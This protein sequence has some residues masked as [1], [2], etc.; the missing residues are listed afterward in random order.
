MAMFP[1]P[2]TLKLFACCFLISCL[3]VGGWVMAQEGPFVS[4]VEQLHEPLQADWITAPGISGNEA[5]LYYFRKSF[6]LEEAPESFP[7]H[8]SGDMRY[9]LLVNGKEVGWGPAVGDLNH[10]NYE[11]YDLAPWLRAGDNVLL[12]R[13]WNVGP[14]KGARQVSHQTGFI[15]QEEKGLG[16]GV[17]TDASWDVA[18]HEGWHP[19]PQSS[20]QAGGGYIA[21]ATDSLVMALDPLGPDLA[22]AGEEIW[23]PVR[24][25]GKGNHGGLN[26]WLG[27]PWLL[28]E[29][30][31][32]AMEQHYEATPAV[33]EVE[34][35]DLELSALKGN[36]RYGCP[37]NSKVRLLLDNRVLTMGFPELKVSGGSDAQVRIRYQEGLFDEYGRKGNRD[38]WQGKQMR[39][40]SDVFLPD[41]REGAVLR[42]LWIRVFR[43]V[44]IDIET[45]D[46][47]LQLEGF[48]NLFTAYPLEEKGSFTADSPGLEAIWEASWRTLRLCAL[49]TYMDCP[50]YE[51]LQYI[52]DTRIQALIS[53]LVA[54]DERL[55][56]QAMAQF[57]HSMQPMGLTKSSHPQSGIQIIPPFSLIYIGM[58]HD[59][60][61]M[62]KD[63]QHIA[64]YLPGVRF[65]LDWF[66]PRIGDDGMMGPL[67]Y[68]NHVD[69]G[70]R[71]FR[72]GSPPG[73]EEGG[74]AHMSILLAWAMQ[75]AADMF[76]YFGHDCDPEVYRERAAGLLE[77]TL[78]QCW[79][80]ER[81]LLA[82]TPEKELYT[83]HS[84][85]MAILAGAFEG[86][87]EGQ[88]ARRMLEDPELAQATLYFKFYL[89]QALKKA[90]LGG[91]ILGEM[92]AW[93]EFLD[94]GLST[95]PEHGAE[96]RS[97][98]HAWAAHPMYSFLN[99]SCGIASDAP[100]FK[101][102]RIAP[103]L[104][105]LGHA[106]GLACHPQGKIRVSFRREGDGM[107]ARIS[108]PEGLSGTL[109]WKGRE[110]P[111]RG[112]EQSFEL[113]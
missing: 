22:K 40:I 38:H 96:S 12:A 59:Y 62:G 85:A 111:L 99:V 39:G 98:C 49:E 71:E 47:A 80:D 89:F 95:F 94:L 86:G 70:T 113:K 37:P 92:E 109:V 69:G 58:I 42:P 57:Y 66:V 102:V 27:T 10:W 48:R 77:S 53:L 35:L 21:G 68:W 112:G 54:G 63:P 93:K 20:L 14:H 87:E 33:V 11:S 13:V 90:G 32:P 72:H 44:Q 6:Q 23:Q 64:S 29:R 15:L 60:F 104:G 5:G 45:G 9:Q 3:S 79:D 73:I 30:S 16:A 7:V 76:E 18:V 67:P 56:R 46:E 101:R 88:V 83:Q 25:L 51:Q 31:I 43:Y 36:F 50:Y 1:T 91:A 74:S 65:I 4:R 78:E 28:Q 107:Q 105:E 52:G 75:K 84:N 100:G 41:G 103:Q 8:V 2:R 108:L 61:M 34:G 17:S 26:T 106:E 82:E 97:D 55:M 19:L 24:I 110:L 81:G